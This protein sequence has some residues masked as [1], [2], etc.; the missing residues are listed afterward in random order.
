[1]MLLTVICYKI[2]TTLCRS[3]LPLALDL[4]KNILFIEIQH[5]SVVVFLL[6]VKYIKFH[7]SFSKFL[8]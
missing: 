4:N 2:L 6:Y 8:F 3:K 5:I 7:T 1:M